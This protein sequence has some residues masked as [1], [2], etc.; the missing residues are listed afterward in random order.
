MT[1]RVRIRPRALADIAEI[2]QYIA[3]RA[4]N[5]ARNLLKR[6]NDRID[7]IGF[8]PKAA[9]LRPDIGPGYRV[10]VVSPYLIFYRLVGDEAVVIRVVDGRQDLT[11]L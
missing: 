6:I 5:A 1:I 2:Y 11:R 9:Q 3:D 10:A 4:P 8:A 7:L